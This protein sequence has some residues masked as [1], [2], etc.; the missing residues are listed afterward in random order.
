M[1]LNMLHSSIIALA[2]LLTG[3]STEPDNS[4]QL[5]RN[6]PQLFR[7]KVDSIQHAT[8]VALNDTVT[9]R[10]YGVIGGDGCHS[11]S[12]FKENKQSLRLDIE[13]WGTRSPARICS[14]VMV[15]LNGKQYKFIAYQRGKL[16]INIHQP[17][18]SVLTDSVLVQ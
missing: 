7:V 9:L 13:V 15:Y 10:M 3:C 12:H 6:S 11:F 8:S 16:Y 18:G 17:D 2:V 1:K 5:F 4:S 14:A